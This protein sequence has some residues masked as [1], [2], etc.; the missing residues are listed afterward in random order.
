MVPLLLGIPTNSGSDGPAGGVDVVIVV[1][2]EVGVEEVVITEP[3][4][5][6]QIHIDS[7]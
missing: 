4:E 6:Q 7:S 5:T 3:P 2:D 1:V